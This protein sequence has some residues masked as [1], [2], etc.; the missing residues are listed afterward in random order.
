MKNI[1]GKKLSSLV[2]FPWQ[3]NCVVKYFLFPSFNW[4]V[5]STERK[6]HLFSFSWLKPKTTL[7]LQI[8]SLSADYDENLCLHNSISSL[9][10]FLIF[11]LGKGLQR[12]VA[13]LFF[14]SVKVAASFSLSCKT[15]NYFVPLGKICAG[16]IT[17]RD[18]SPLQHS[19]LD[20]I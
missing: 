19:S 9:N 10:Y 8:I 13:F 12:L 6:E 7:Y 16:Q 4:E 11:D 15:L 3:T 20:D 14:L 5:V 18:T 17:Y 2:S 1:K